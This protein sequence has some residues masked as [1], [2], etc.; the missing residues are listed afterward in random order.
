[1]INELRELRK[2]YKLNLK[3]LD[4]DKIAELKAKY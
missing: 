4:E 2:E 1:M 3:A